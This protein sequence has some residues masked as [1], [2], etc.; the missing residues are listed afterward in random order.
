MRRIFYILPLFLCSLSFGQSSDNFD[1]YANNDILGDQANW[2]AENSSI[3]IVKPASDGEAAPN[4]AGVESS[5]YYVGTFDADQYSQG[6]FVGVEA[7][8]Y[9]VGVS[10]RNSTSGAHDYYGFYTSATS[11]YLFK[12]DNGAFTTLAQGNAWTAGDVVKLEVVDDTLK[13]YRN[14]S[15]DASISGDGVLVDASYSTGSPGICGFGNSTTTRIDDWSGGN[16][17]GEPPAETVGYQHFIGESQYHGYI[18]GQLASNFVSDYSQPPLTPGAYGFDSTYVLACKQKYCIPEDVNNGDYVG[19]WRKTWTW[20]SSGSYSFSLID[21]HDGAFAINSSTGLITISDATKI[22]GKILQQDTAINLIVRTVDSDIGFELDTAEVWVKENSYTI[23]V[24]YSQGT[25]GSGTRTSPERDF[26]EFTIQAGRG[27]F[28]RRGTYIN[29]ESTSIVGVVGSVAH[30]TIIAAY[31]DGNI[32]FFNGSGLG[33]GVNNRCFVVGQSTETSPSS[34]LSFYDLK[35]RGYYSDAFYIWRQSSNIGIYNV[36][37]YNNCQDYSGESSLTYRTSDYGDSAVVAPIE[38]INMQAD[39]TQELYNGEYNNG[40]AF[41]K[42]GTG[43]AHVTNSRFGHSHYDG[44]RFT[45]GRGHILRYCVV[46]TGST[47]MSGWCSAIQFRGDNGLIEGCRIIGNYQ[48]IYVV[49][50]GGGKGWTYELYP[51]S[52]H[53]KNTL[54]LGQFG[55]GVQF[56]PNGDVN[57]TSSVGDIIEDCYFKNTTLGIWFRDLR[58]IIIRRN[59]IAETNGTWGIQSSGTE[60][61]TGINIYYNE[62]YGFSTDEI[63]IPLSSGLTLYHNT[64]DGTIDLAGSTSP[65]TRNNFFRSSTTNTS[66]NIDLDEITETDYFVNYAS[67]NFALKSTATDAINHGY[68]LNLS[69]DIIGTSEQEGTEDIGA[70]EYIP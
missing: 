30:P 13:C 24:D 48:G 60:T 6:T 20:M 67:K 45:C 35:I 41:F 15:L 36:E 31:D 54:L 17:S 65:V 28:V 2:N 7:G 18:G 70:H 62:I 49:P 25:N 8:G 42:I 10:V 63:E 37:L 3:I 40:V 22:N 61:S 14:G 38:I 57:Y 23:F 26:D 34:Y 52:F 16:T 56:W 46:Q 5:A 64:I 19:T 50:P 66:N 43:P 58:D 29:G 59:I 53:L 51:D 55:Y 33:S 44:I 47:S 4:Q 32:P 27:Y 11:S 69:P 1:S 39:S 12:V 21:D 9:S 68:N